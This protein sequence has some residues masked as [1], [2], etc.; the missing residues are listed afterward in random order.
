M[1]R[2][3]KKKEPMPEHEKYRD[4]KDKYDKYFSENQDTNNAEKEKTK[5]KKTKRKK[6]KYLIN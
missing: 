1:A 5:N 4:I 6:Q 2:Y 3:F